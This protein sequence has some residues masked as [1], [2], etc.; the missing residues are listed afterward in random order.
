MKQWGGDQIELSFKAW[1]CGG[2]IVVVPCGRVG[3]LFRDVAHRPYPV[4][5]PQVVENYAKLA[6]VWLEP[7]FLD[8]FYLVKP[9]SRKMALDVDLS[10]PISTMKKLQCKSMKWYVENVDLEL[11]WE[12][13]K[14][15]IPGARGPI[16]CE[17][18]AYPGRATIDRVIPLD[19]Y[20]VRALRS[21]FMKPQKFK[22]KGVQSKPYL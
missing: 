8:A 16:G 18:A 21:K 6:R 5:I 19:E 9:E 22:T 13:D 1:R 15:C 20:N 7:P 17:N 3:H 2:S 12:A 14:I 10:T 4:D 11:G